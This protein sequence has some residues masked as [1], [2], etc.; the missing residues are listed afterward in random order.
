MAKK[1]TNERRKPVKLLE[2]DITRMSDAQRQSLIKEVST[3]MPPV[4]KPGGSVP[5]NLLKGATTCRST[6]KR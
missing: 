5:F 3:G 4:A 2:T 6:Q 1:T